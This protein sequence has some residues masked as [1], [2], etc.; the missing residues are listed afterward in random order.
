MNLIYD[1]EIIRCIPSKGVRMIE[2]DSSKWLS[3]FGDGLEYCSGWDDFENMGISVVGL[4]DLNSGY[5]E[6]FILNILNPDP[7]P[8]AG[9]SKLQS[10]FLENK[11]LGFNSR[12]FD[13]NLCKAHGLSIQTSFD[14]LEEVRIAAYGSPSWE[15]QPPGFRYN[16]DAIARAN[17]LA[18]TGHGELAPKLWQ[19]G[20]REE[21]A[22]YCLNDVAIT[23]GLLLKFLDG[24]LIDPNTGNLLKYEGDL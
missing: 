19:E 16:L 10:L 4:A 24:N 20:K 13:D 22:D 2:E 12:N 14:L 1:C 18:K 23:K 6:I 21:V 9:F 8:P 3:R 11:I 15:D 5:S 7:I 17:G